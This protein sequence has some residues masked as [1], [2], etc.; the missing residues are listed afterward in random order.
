MGEIFERFIPDKALDWTGE[1]LTSAISGQAEIEHLHRYFLARELCRDCDVIDLG[2]GEGYGSALLAQVARS[3]VGIDVSPLAV[4]HARASYASPR[5]RFEEGDARRLKLPEASVDRIVCFETLPRLDDPEAVMAVAARLLRPDGLLLLSM[6]ARDVPSPSPSAAA[7]SAFHV[8]ELSRAELEALVRRHF[9]HVR[10]LAQRA[11]LGS[12]LAPDGVDPAAGL[13]TFEK[14]GGARYEVNAGMPHASCLLA[15]ASATALPP[16]PVS[17]FIE[18]GAVGTVLE[19]AQGGAALE[20]QLKTALASVDRLNADIE[21]YRREMDRARLLASHETAR[22]DQARQEVERTRR[23]SEMFRVVA[24][25]SFAVLGTHASTGATRNS[26]GRGGDH[27]EWRHLYED[28]EARRAQLEANV[29]GLAE[30]C[31]KLEHELTVA[32]RYTTNLVRELD[33]LR[34]RYEP[35]GVEINTLKMELEQWRSRY[36]RLHDRVEKMIRRVTPRIWR[37]AVRRKLLGPAE[38]I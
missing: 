27:K 13:I 32:H 8:R 18:D 22:L 38:E 30:R 31:A 33:G 14:R 17:L 16:S 37:K 20:G 7:A 29:A 15:I 24:S 10:M 1:R 19:R 21:H 3:V 9:P 2:C 11:M 5:L 26:V 36:F 6:P 23:E 34:G 25:R 28:S 12:S 35:G 4:A